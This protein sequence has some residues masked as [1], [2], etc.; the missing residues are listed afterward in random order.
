[1]IQSDISFHRLFNQS[2]A[3]PS[4]EEPADVLS[5]LGAIQGQD[6]IG[7][8]WSLG[9]R[10][11]KSTDT[12]IEEAFT[13]KKILRT[14]LMRGTLHFVASK[15]IDWIRKLVAEKI[16]AGNARR[17]KELELD[18]PTLIKGNNLL[19]KFLQRGQPVNRKELLTSLER[20]GVSTAGQRA[21]YIL[22]R[23]SLDGLICQTNTV[24]NSPNYVLLDS[25]F[26]GTKAKT[27]DEA[28]A[29]LTK[30]YFTSRG[31]A[32]VQDFVWWSGLT[33]A[34][35]KAGLDA[36]KSVLQ[37]ESFEGQEYWLPSNSQLP[38]AGK[39]RIYFLPGFD[40]FLLGYKDRSASL[41]PAYNNHWCPGGN[42]MFFPVVVRNGQV[43]G[44][45]KREFKKTSV[46]IGITAFHDLKE[47]Q[48]HPDFKPVVQKFSDFVG[49]ELVMQNE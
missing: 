2:I 38:I 24:S 23:A 4:F 37:Q 10:L 17:Y 31:P 36:N 40:E 33:V 32:T 25:S 27:R 20:Y 15:D 34:E 1:M 12:V 5:W 39:D 21:A 28:I 30:R 46:F 35:T 43:S 6:Y 3:D 8:K 26:A 41:D 18:E 22:Q 29:E 49:M 44:I 42:G 7:A 48:D 47:L 16:I 11:P 45:W 14:W 9:L 19:L 13:D